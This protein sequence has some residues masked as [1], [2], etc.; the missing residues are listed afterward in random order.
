M[1]GPPGMKPGALACAIYVRCSAGQRSRP[2]A[3][4]AA[5]HGLATRPRPRSRELLIL[6]RKRRRR[7][8]SRTTTRPPR[9][10]LTLDPAPCVRRR[11]ARRRRHGGSGAA[12]APSSTT[13]SSWSPAGPHQSVRATPP[14]ALTPR[15]PCRSSPVINRG[16]DQ[17]ES[18]PRL[19]TCPRRAAWHCRLCVR[20]AAGDG[21]C[22]RAGRGLAS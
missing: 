6:P 3:R 21:S 7:A 11:A 18:H 16:S 12:R 9:A 10:T 13:S 8:R 15:R 5:K 1:D 4:Q 22:G 14:P 19:L 2:R 20:A 17:C